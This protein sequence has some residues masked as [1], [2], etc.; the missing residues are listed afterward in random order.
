MYRY[1][2]LSVCHF[3]FEANYES[4]NILVTS[5]LKSGG[6]VLLLAH[7][8]FDFAAVFHILANLQDC[9]GIKIDLG[10]CGLGNK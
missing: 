2:T 5:K 10:N 8:V 3:A 4:M 6:S 1:I 7:N 9:S